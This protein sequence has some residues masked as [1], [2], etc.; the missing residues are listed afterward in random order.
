MKI[1]PVRFIRML[2]VVK[3]N[4]SITC[5]I[6]PSMIIS[7]RQI[8]KDF[9]P[10]IHFAQVKYSKF[11]GLAYVTVNFHKTQANSSNFIKIRRITLTNLTKVNT[12]ITQLC[13]R[14]K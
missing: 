5:N 6:V 3:Q 10:D 12:R 11:F 1:F 8:V 2:S 9:Y 13:Y 4:N 14:C 7:S